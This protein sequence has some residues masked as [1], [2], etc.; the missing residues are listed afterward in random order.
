[1]E[2]N[3]GGP[4]FLAH[5]FKSRGEPPD[6]EKINNKLK[7]AFPAL[8]LRVGEW[9]EELTERSSYRM[10]KSMSLTL[11]RMRNSLQLV[12]LPW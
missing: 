9:W 8:P 12:L 2:L 5:T 11:L 6:G 7:S 4:P 10:L 1:M 3:G